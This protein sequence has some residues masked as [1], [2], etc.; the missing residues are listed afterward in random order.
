MGS[1]SLFDDN[2][3]EEEPLT[4]EDEQIDQISLSLNGL[5]NQDEN[6]YIKNLK[7]HQRHSP[8]PASRHPDSI[9]PSL[10][11]RLYDLK[12]RL[13]NEPLSHSPT[14][15]HAAKRIY[16]NPFLLMKMKFRWIHIPN[17]FLYTT[18]LK[19]TI[20]LTIQ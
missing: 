13:F 19:T 2:A 18:L 9:F 7:K 14:P 6:L 10:F 20:L 15:H 8:A 12:Q 5:I 3:I 4:E 17:S 1:S 16:E 11:D